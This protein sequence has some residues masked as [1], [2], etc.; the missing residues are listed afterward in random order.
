M[1]SSHNVA[2]PAMIRSA[3]FGPLVHDRWCARQV[4]AAQ[5]FVLDADDVLAAEGGSPPR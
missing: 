5:V 2:Q 1:P 3:R 4:I